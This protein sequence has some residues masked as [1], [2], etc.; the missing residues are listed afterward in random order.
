MIAALYLL[1]VPALWALILGAVADLLILWLVPIPQKRK[2][3]G[4]VGGSLSFSLP[5]KSGG[6]SDG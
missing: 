6:K 5:K 1:G 3:V 2:R 4:T